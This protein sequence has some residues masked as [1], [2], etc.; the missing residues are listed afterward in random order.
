MTQKVQAAQRF[1][2]T[3]IAAVALILGQPVSSWGDD[4]EARKIMEKVDA[5]ENGDNQTSD[6]EMILIDKKGSERIRKIAYFYKYK[7]KDR[8]NMMFFLHPADVR[9]TAFLTYDYD[10]PEKDDDQWLYLPA[11]GKTK[12][13]ASAD[14]SGSFMG[15]DLNYSDMATPEVANY[16]Y[17][18]Y[19]KGRE[20]EFDG[21]KTWAI[22]SRPR[23]QKV[24]RETGYSKSLLFIR[25]DNYVVIRTIS[26][27]ENGGPLKYMIVKKLDKIDGVW[28]PTEMQVA[29]KQGKQTIHQTILKFKNV[30]FNQDLD[31]R[32][33][34]VRRMEKG[35]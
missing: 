18:F 2:L 27:V 23:S 25:Q 30:K 35:F 28:V 33:F 14:K 17:S 12:R 8:L 10:D 16:D 13:I 24:V 20:K 34:S 15:S 4:P 1:G 3:L 7:S 9:N 29:K 6:L 32:F 22:W 31:E 21:F 11:L 5:Q 26:W 19:E